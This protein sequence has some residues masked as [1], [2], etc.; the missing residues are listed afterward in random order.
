MGDPS[1]L[2]ALRRAYAEE[3]EDS[4]YKETMRRAIGDLEG[5]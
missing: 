5:G 4:S 2:P 1:A 3:P